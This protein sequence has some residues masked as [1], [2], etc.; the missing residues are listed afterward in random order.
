MP[1]DGR[2]G[3]ETD[4]VPGVS[5]ED[6]FEVFD[7]SLNNGLQ[8]KTLVSDLCFSGDHDLALGVRPERRHEPALKGGPDLVGQEENGCLEEISL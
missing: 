3:D 5:V 6:A 2:T 8:D 7:K 1:Y 4:E